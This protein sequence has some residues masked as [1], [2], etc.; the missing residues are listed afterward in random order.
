MRICRV[1]LTCF[2][3]LLP[4]VVLSKERA[5]EIEPVKA[6]QRSEKEKAEILESYH[7]AEVAAEKG[8]RDAMLV[9]GRAYHLGDVYPQDPSKAWDWYIKSFSLGNVLALNNI[10]IMFRDGVGTP[11]N[12]KVAYAILLWIHMEIG[13]PEDVMSYV[14][15][16]LREL[17]AVLPRKDREEALSYTTEYL[18]QVIK[19]HGLKME[20]EPDV[21]PS[22]TRLRIKDKDWWLPSERKQLNFR[23]PPPWN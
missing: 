8:N 19:S 12:Y 9:L 16:N 21:L 13:A 4:I 20:P 15:P 23:S 2:V 10:A 22:K 3:L 1:W 18:K 5:P 17:V 7:R 11:K 14:N 6:P